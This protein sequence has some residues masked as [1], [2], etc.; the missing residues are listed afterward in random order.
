MPPLPSGTGSPLG[1]SYR[2]LQLLWNPDSRN[3]PRTGHAGDDGLEPP[4][5]LR[6]N[7]KYQIVLC[8]RSPV[9]FS[10]TAENLSGFLAVLGNRGHFVSCDPPVLG[11]G[12]IA[13]FAPEVAVEFPLSRMQLSEQAIE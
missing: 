3:H 2:Q 11:D 10:V 5:P 13:R 7:S 6:E 1:G 8:A 9:A 4:A 12:G